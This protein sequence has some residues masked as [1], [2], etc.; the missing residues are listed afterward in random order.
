[1]RLIDLTHTFDGNMP[2]YPGDP[3]PQL[4]QTANIAE[5]GYNEY[6]LTCGM[7]VGTHMDAPLHMIPGGRFM[8]EISP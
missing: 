5:H 4:A 7:H 2:V 8:S 6:S 3:V 1:M